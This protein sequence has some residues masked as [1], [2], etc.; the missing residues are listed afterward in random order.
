MNQRLPIFVLGFATIF[1]TLNV[2]RVKLQRD[3]WRELAFKWETNFNAVAKEC[4]KA[5][6]I[7]KDAIE[8]AK[9][10]QANEQPNI[11]KE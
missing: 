9:R 6:T 10:I 1:Q 3:E 8:V 5:Q 4:M 11:P 7:A 2:T